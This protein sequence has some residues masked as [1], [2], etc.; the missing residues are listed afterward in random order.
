MTANENLGRTCKKC[1]KFKL[2]DCFGKK[3]GGLNGRNSACKDCRNREYYRRQKK[4]MA[5][6][7]VVIDGENFV[8]ESK[9]VGKPCEATLDAVA[10][11]I[12]S[13]Y[14]NLGGKLC[15]EKR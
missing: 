5:R 7:R 14:E 2:W 13:A 15:I 8:I 9:V 3:A 4:M 11:I 12:V 10:R 1:N 6:K